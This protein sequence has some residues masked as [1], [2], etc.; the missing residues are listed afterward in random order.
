MVSGLFGSRLE[1]SDRSIQVNVKDFEGKLNVNEHCDWIASLQAFFEW[2]YLTN[3]RKVQFVATKLKGHALIWWQ[4]YQ[5]SRDQRG[6]LRV[7]T[8]AEMKLKLDEKFLP[9]NYSQTLNQKFHQLHQQSDQSVLL[10]G[11]FLQAFESCQFA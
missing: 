4:Q 7:N 2:K 11:V 6:I 1:N 10:Y 5:R 9:L 8:W 3:E